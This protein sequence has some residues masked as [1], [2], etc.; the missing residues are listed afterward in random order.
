MTKI[1]RDYMDHNME[2]AEVVLARLCDDPSWLI[3]LWLHIDCLG[4][5]YPYVERTEGPWYEGLET[6]V[7]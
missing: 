2:R 6:Y 1:T 7:E 4:T 5:G 3:K